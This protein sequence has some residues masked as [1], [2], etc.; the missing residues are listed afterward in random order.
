MEL[1]N[2]IL[3]KLLLAI[4]VGGIIG[5]ER[6]YR[7]KSAGFRTLILISFGAALFTIFSISLGGTESA[8]RIAANIVVGIGFIGAGVIFKEGI[9]VNGITTA[10]TIWVTAALGM[11]IGAGYYWV[12]I[13]GA[14]LVVV[15][16]Y[17]FTYFE[18]FIDKNNQLRNYKIEY[19]FNGR[20][21][22]EFEE[23]LKQFKLNIRSSH[24]KRSGDSMK[25]RWLV[26]GSETD[27]KL[28]IEHILQKDTIREFEF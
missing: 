2:D 26:Q 8:T 19:P 12:S 27:H 14:L 16:L 21:Q 10:A 24:Q 4:L 6:E 1:N 15:I 3:I 17:V 20:N 9:R 13:I 25:G 23:L 18:R 7:S 11:G 22:H 5:M 28:F